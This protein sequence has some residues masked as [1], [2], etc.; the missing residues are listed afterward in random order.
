VD[1][2]TRQKIANLKDTDTLKGTHTRL[3]LLVPTKDID[4]KATASETR[5]DKANDILVNYKLVK[6]KLLGPTSVQLIL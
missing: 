6:Y 4:R 5:F 3:C 2:R 1:I